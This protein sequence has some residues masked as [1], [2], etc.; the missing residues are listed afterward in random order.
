MGAVKTG[1][2]RG[3]AVILSLVAA[4]LFV[5]MGYFVLLAVLTVAYNG[6]DFLLTVML[7]LLCLIGFGFAVQGAKR[8]WQS[9][10]RND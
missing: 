7:A 2:G 8:L 4:A 5:G 9:E 10:K 1:A 6:R 3:F